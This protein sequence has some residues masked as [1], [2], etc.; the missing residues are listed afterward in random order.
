M[1]ASRLLSIQMLLQAR[2][3]VSA[4]VLARELEVSVRTLY[5]DVEELAAAGVPIFAERGRA[6]GFQLLAGWKPTLAGLTPT[7]SQ[8]VFLSGL[9]GPAAELG[10]GSAVE[11][12]KLKLLAAMPKEWRGQAERVASRLYL[13]PLDWYRDTEPAPHLGAIAAAVWEPR[14]LALEYESWKG[15]VKR[16]VSPLGLVLKSG[17]WYFVAAVDDSPRTFKVA[18]VRALGVLEAPARRPKGFDL[19]AYWRE[20]VQRFEQQLLQGRATVLADAA[21]VAQLRRENGAVARAVPQQLD[22]AHGRARIVIP[23]E[24]IEQATSL[25]IRLAPEVEV[26]EPAALR[27]SIERRLRAAARRYRRRRVA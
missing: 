16:T 13:D 11:A 25:F 22:T 4:S 27:E 26:I 3:R 9:A 14:L 10:F 1:R 5:R 12:A 2:G 17:A 18:N 23:I 20:S 7:E 21:G 24:S 6:G 15:V 19:P 8:A